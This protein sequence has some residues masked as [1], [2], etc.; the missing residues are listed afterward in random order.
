MATTDF[1]QRKQLQA[2][3]G[4]LFTTH[5]E[6]E[7]MKR[8]RCLGFTHQIRT[9]RANLP[10]IA[11]FQPRK[12]SPSSF[13]KIAATAVGIRS[14]SQKPPSSQ[15]PQR[16]VPMSAR[17]DSLGPPPKRPQEPRPSC[18]WPL[19]QRRPRFLCNAARTCTPLRCFRH[20][21]LSDHYRPARFQRRYP[22][23]YRG[24]R[25]IHSQEHPDRNETRWPG[26]TRCPRD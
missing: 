3:A 14:Q 18:R 12:S 23:P 7:L 5:I 6:G 9:T 4:L 22:H 19:P 21:H 13:A 8:M 16:S 17:L 2:D 10:K 25:K 11:N 1:H 15:M 20:L 24:S 26:P